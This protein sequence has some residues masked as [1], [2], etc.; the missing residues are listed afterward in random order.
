MTQKVNAIANGY[1]ILKLLASQTAARGVTEIAKSTSISPSSCFNILRTLVDLDLAIFNEKTKG[2][3]LGPGIFELAR[4]GMSYD[5]IVTA[6][7]PVLTALAQK[8][9]ATLGLWDIVNQSEAMLIAMGE[10]SSLARLSMQIGSRQPIAAGATGRANLSM[11][12]DDNDTSWLE[13]KFKEVQWQGE[14]SFNDYLKD[15]KRAR[16]RGYGVDRDKY[17]LGI[18]T[19]SSAFN[20]AKTG[21]RYCLTAVLLSGAHSAK[22]IDAVGHELLSEAETLSNYFLK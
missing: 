15:I 12:A 1:A 5:T 22:T 19:V 2:Y 9:N 16:K 18:S 7:Q 17:Y 10:N 14:L 21:R 4:N 20:N 11:R 8:H 13:S 6:A 3:T